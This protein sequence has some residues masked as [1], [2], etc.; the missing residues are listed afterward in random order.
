MTFAKEVFEGVEIKSCDQHKKALGY[1]FKNVSC[2]MFGQKMKG[3][4][5]VRW[6]GKAFEI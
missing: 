1:D 6:N 4:E 5:D 2:W 3:M